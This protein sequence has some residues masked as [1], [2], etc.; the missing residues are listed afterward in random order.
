M[1]HEPMNGLENELRQALERRPAPPSLKRK[2][3]ER[4][5]AL[6]FKRRHSRV[7]WWQRLAIAGTL[8]GVLAG[9][10]VWR[11]AEEQRREQRRGEEVRREVMVALRITSRALNQMQSQLQAHNRDTQIQNRDAQE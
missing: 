1:G 9:A 11:H 2:I 7:V 4:R 5:D 8:A 10:L 6:H 3:M